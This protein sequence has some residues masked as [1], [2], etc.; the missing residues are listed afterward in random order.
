MQDS[1]RGRIPAGVTHGAPAPKRPPRSAPRTT[2]W[3]GRDGG[4]PRF[5]GPLNTDGIFLAAS[6]RDQK[7]PRQTTAQNPIA[8][9]EDLLLPSPEHGSVPHRVR[10]ILGSPTSQEI[11]ARMHFHEQ[12]VLLLALPTAKPPLQNLQAQQKH[13]F[14]IIRMATVRFCWHSKATLQRGGRVFWISFLPLHCYLTQISGKLLPG[15]SRPGSR[16]GPQPTLNPCI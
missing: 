16:D 1:G 12:I 7:E 6:K 2:L 3:A 4:E 13:H 10:A 9:T 15:H 5:Q 8:G 14:A 11:L